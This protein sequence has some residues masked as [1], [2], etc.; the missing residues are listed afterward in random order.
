[1]LSDGWSCGIPWPQHVPLL[2]SHGQQGS[3]RLPPFGFE[4]LGRH[5]VWAT[6]H[7]DN[8]VSPKVLEKVGLGAKGPRRDD[9]YVGGAWY[10]S[11]V[12]SILEDEWRLRTTRS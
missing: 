1:M 3:C 10:D 4:A 2:M 7:P 6:H 12:G 11:V 9:R 5:G 8:L